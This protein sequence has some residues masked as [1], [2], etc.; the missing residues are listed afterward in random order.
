MRREAMDS[1]VDLKSQLDDIDRL[2]DFPTVMAICAESDISQLRDVVN[3]IIHMDQNNDTPTYYALGEKLLLFC[4]EYHKLPRADV[5][6]AWASGIPQAVAMAALRVLEVRF[7]SRKDPRRNKK[8]DFIM[9][10][11]PAI[12]QMATTPFTVYATS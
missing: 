9:S 6:L 7:P 10:L 1:I 11:V 5:L 4:E 8:C 2:S 3:D 12:G